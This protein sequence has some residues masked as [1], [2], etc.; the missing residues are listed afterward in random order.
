M[1]SKKELIFKNGLWE[2]VV[3][4]EGKHPITSRLFYKIKKD[5]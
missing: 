5:A 2:K 1:E 4:F 3:G